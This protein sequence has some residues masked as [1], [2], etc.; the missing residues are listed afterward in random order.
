MAERFRT[1]GGWL[2]DLIG[3]LKVQHMENTQNEVNT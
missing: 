1:G 2:R 3:T